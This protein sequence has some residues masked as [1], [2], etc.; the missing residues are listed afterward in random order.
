MEDRTTGPGRPRSG[1]IAG[2]TGKDGT[3]LAELLLG[4]DFAAMAAADLERVA[5]RGVGC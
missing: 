3:D 1:L 4:V 5:G 2:V